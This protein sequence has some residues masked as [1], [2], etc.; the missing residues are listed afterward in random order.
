MCTY[1]LPPALRGKTACFLLPV[2]KGQ[3]SRKTRGEKGDRKKEERDHKFIFTHLR[4]HT[5]E[6]TN[7]FP[8]SKYSIEVPVIVEANGEL[9]KPRNLEHKDILCI[10]VC[11]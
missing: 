8:S 9:R 10:C 3:K 6:C 5:V 11:E 2:E 4:I 1:R 7:S